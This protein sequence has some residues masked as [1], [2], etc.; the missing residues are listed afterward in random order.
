ME[1][2]KKNVRYGIKNIAPKGESPQWAIVATYFGT[3]IEAVAPCK[4]LEE[5]KGRYIQIREQ[6]RLVWKAIYV[7]MLEMKEELQADPLPV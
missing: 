6:P 2:N 3:D 1:F 4:D 7:K 5:A